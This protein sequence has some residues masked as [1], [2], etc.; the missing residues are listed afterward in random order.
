MVLV[1]IG[2]AIVNIHIPLEGF[3]ECKV[4]ETIT[5]LHDVFGNDLRAF[6]RSVLLAYAVGVVDDLLL[7]LVRGKEQ[8][9]SNRYEG[10][11]DEKK[12]RQNSS[13]RQD[14]LPGR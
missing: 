10:N 4:N 2:E 5:L 12:C 13:S 6:L 14:G 1:E 9:E 8:S 7:H 3:V 11:S